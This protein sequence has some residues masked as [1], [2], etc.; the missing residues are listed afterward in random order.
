MRAPEIVFSGG[1]KP[2]IEQ[3]SGFARRERG[4]LGPFRSER[5]DEES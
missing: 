4:H 5:I 2:C 3:L 1:A